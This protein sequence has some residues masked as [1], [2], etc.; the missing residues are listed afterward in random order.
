[1]LWFWAI[2]KV[3]HVYS[4]DRRKDMA[5]CKSSYHGWVTDCQV[6]ISPRAFKSLRHHANRRPTRSHKQLSDGTH[7]LHERR[8]PQQTWVE[9]N[10]D[11]NLPNIIKWWFLAYIRLE[12]FANVKIYFIFI[13]HCL[14]WDVPTDPKSVPF[15]DMA[16]YRPVL[17]DLMA[18]TPT[19]TDRISIR[20]EE[21]KKRT[22]V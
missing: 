11:I 3:C 4:G 15:L 1:M 19:L 2:P 10:N 17:T 14:L 13:F 9:S 18:T 20:P 7:W 16:R 5:I 22:E 12:V 8:K 6:E 21:W